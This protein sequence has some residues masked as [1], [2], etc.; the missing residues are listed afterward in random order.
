MSEIAAAD[1]VRPDVFDDDESLV[2][3]R[4]IL[5]SEFGP[6]G[7]A[8]A[9]LTAQLQPDAAARLRSRLRA[10]LTEVVGPT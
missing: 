2:D 3:L 10:L 9:A 6:D 4:A 7:P 5:W 1:N 8:T